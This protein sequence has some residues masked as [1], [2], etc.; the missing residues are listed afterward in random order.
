M[1]A[2]LEISESSE[3]RGDHETDHDEPRLFTGQ[4]SVDGEQHESQGDAEVPAGEQPRLAGR[5]RCG[6]SITSAGAVRP[7]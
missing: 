3:T 7:Q 4:N 5:E 2:Q 6:S 1:P